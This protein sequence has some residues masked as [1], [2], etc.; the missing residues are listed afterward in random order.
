MGEPRGQALAS[1]TESWVC[2]SNAMGWV[3]VRTTARVQAISRIEHLRAHKVLVC[4]VCWRGR[5]FLEVS[6]FLCMFCTISHVLRA[7]LIVA[8]GMLSRCS[9]T[10]PCRSWVHRM[11]S[12][13]SFEFHTLFLTLPWQWIG[14]GVRA[15]PCDALNIINPSRVPFSRRIATSTSSAAHLTRSYLSHFPSLPLAL[16][17]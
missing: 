1:T 14:N 12:N 8:V 9:T 17:P 10:T 11:H 13:V 3:S 16:A 4:Y 7:S 5:F 6:R 15:I 2:A